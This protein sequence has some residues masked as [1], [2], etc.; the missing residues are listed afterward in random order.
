MPAD[1]R[2]P[3]AQ[4]PAVEHRTSIWMYHSVAS[5]DDDPYG[6]T[7]EPERLDHQLRWLRE[8]GLKGVGMSDLLRARTTGR[9]AGLVGLTFDDGYADFLDHAL[10]LLQRYGFTATVFVLAGRLDGVNGWDPLGPRKR[11]L[12]LGG[13][14]RIAAAG[15]EV[16]SHG[17]RHTRLT[18]LAPSE[19][20]RE[21]VESRTVLSHI[22]DCVPPGFCYPYG[23]LNARVVEAV[24]AA[25]YSYACAIAPQP[26]HGIFAL[27]RI[28][29]SQA[30]RSWRLRLK[31]RL[32]GT[33]RCAG[34]WQLPPGSDR[35]GRP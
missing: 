26:E 11:L 27:P 28:H 22:T 2:A 34:A 9:G 14:R 6:I 13:I 23:E 24:R 12:S 25:G 4:V 15:M 21:V 33:S 10:P 19:L 8:R 29:I 18:Q 32:Q 17:L 7:V 30:D 31:H 1:T 3:R 20:H 35:G 5:A 16:G